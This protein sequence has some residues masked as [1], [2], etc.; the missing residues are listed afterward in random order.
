MKFK[1]MLIAAASLAAIAANAVTLDFEGFANNTEITNQYAGLGVNFSGGAAAWFGISNGDPG[2]WGLEGTAGPN[3]LGNNG[4]GAGGKVVRMDF[5]AVQSNFSFDISRSNGSAAGS[6]FKTRLYD[7]NNTMI[8][9]QTWTFEDINQWHNYG[10]VGFSIYGFE[11]ESITQGFNPYGI[12]NVQYDAVPEPA[13]MA[14]LAVAGLGL[15]A[16]RRKN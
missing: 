11:I 3:F 7:I 6:Q 8:L 4:T 15:L 13:T 10:W 1:L 2:N 9:E 16:R 5:D 14:V 12:D